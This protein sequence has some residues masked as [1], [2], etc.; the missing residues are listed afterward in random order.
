MTAQ[1]LDGKALAAD[2]RNALHAA[3]AEYEA[4]GQR[5]PGLA[6]ILVGDDPA[7]EIYVKHKKRDCEQ[8]GFKSDVRHL[9][10]KVTEDDLLTI[11]D[12]LNDDASID[13]ILVQSP[14][15]ENIDPTHVLER[16]GPAKDVDGFHPY[17]LGR[18]AS[19]LPALR[20]CTPKGI[21]TLIESTGVAI[22][23]LEA[24]IVGASNHV[25][26]PMSLELLL[27]GCTVTTAHKFTRDI[28]P[29][30]ARADILVSAVGKPG[31]IRGEWIKPG[32][33]VVDVGITRGDGGKLQGDVDFDVAMERAGWITPVPGGVGPMTRIAV[34][35]NTLQAYRQRMDTESA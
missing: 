15:P 2:L 11:I 7:S 3:V 26:R 27:A 16:I 18:L 32:A 8:V 19:R 25:G 35:Q 29:H 34:L 30:V 1:I 31:L 21:M 33:I 10:D 12:Q 5:P 28:E 22:R 9:S 24:T 4:L 6:V 23:G 20:S 17:N 14:L 13:G